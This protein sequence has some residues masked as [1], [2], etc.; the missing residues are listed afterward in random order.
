MPPRIIPFRFEE[1]IRA[2]S[3]VQVIC[4]VGE[5]DSPIDIRWMLHGEE[6]QPSV[7]IFTQR[8]GERTSIL[9]IN[10]VGSKHRGSYTCLA[11]NRAGVTNH[12]ETLFVNGRTTV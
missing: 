3:L 5:G 10:D 8:F 11:S 7:G 9:S 12:T 1:H 6:V 2:G 4:A